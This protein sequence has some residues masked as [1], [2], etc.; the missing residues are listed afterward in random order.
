VEPEEPKLPEEDQGNS[1][2]TAAETSKSQ[3]PQ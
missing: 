1:G 2:S 3:S